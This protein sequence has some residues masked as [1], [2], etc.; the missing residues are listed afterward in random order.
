MITGSMSIDVPSPDE[1][2]RFYGEAF[3]L[4]KVVEPAPGVLVMGLGNLEVCLLAKP[5]GSR[6]SPNTSDTRRYDRHWTPVHLDF[7]VD[8][9]KAAMARVRDAGGAVEQVFENPEHG[10]AAFCSDPFGHGFCLLERK[11]SA[12]AP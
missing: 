3:G 8:D 9:V 1:G 12:K 10:A 2:A 4:V 6:P 7:H 11:E 5:A